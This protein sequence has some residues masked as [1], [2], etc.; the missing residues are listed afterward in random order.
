MIEVAVAFA[1][2]EAAVAGV[3]RAIALGKDIQECYHDI[4]T[5]FEKQAEIKSVW[6]FCYC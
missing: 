5:F 3:K 2:A 4:G 1:A 6:V